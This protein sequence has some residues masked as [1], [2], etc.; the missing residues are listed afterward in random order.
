MKFIFPSLL[1]ASLEFLII[2]SNSLLPFAAVAQRIRTQAVSSMHTLPGKRAPSSRDQGL[3]NQLL[4]RVP[5]LA[6]SE[7]QHVSQQDLLMYLS[8]DVNRLH[9]TK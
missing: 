8:K 5:A 2:L 3:Q 7:K 6:L 1:P 4:L 9:N